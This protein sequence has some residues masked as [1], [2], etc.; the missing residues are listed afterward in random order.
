MEARQIDCQQSIPSFFR[1]SAALESAED[2]ARIVIPRAVKS[3]Y[4]RRPFLSAEA[5]RSSAGSAMAGINS[6]LDP[7]TSR[8]VLTRNH[9]RNKYMELDEQFESF[10]EAY[11]PARRQRGFMVVQAFVMSVQ[12]VGFDALL[13]AVKQQSESEQWT[14]PAMIPT[15]KKWLEEERWIQVLPA[16]ERRVPLLSKSTQSVIDQLARRAERLR[17]EN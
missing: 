7:K 5:R 2:M 12:K 4:P 15:M 17:H 14:N 16:R 1:D 6:P 13:E 9:D 8:L 10:L 3:D 11:P